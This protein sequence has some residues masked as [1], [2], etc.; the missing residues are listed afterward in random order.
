[1]RFNG[2]WFIK[3]NE[4]KFDKF[5]IQI[6]IEDATYIEIELTAKE[7][8]ELKHLIENTLY[9]KRQ[10]SGESRCMNS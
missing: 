6:G 10:F 1:M 3:E 5:T 7:L 9:T 4:S 8:L 2:K